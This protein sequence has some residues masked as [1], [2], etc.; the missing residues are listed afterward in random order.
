MSFDYLNELSWMKINDFLLSNESIMEPREFCVHVV[1]KIYSL[2]PYD[3]ARIYF[4]DYNGKVSDHVL[5]GVD[6]RWNDV[7]LEYY[8]R[9]ENGHYS[10]FKLENNSYL[11]P[12]INGKVHDWEKE[13]CDEFVSDYIKPQGLYH[14]LGFWLHNGE[15]LVT[16]VYS[17]DRTKH[18]EFT[19][20]EITAVRVVLPHL[21]NLYRN[22][23][24]LASSKMNHNNMEIPTPLTKREKEITELLRKGMT[25]SNISKKLFLSLPTIYK[26]IA[27]I[28][29]K[30]N[31]SNR[32]ELLLKL[33]N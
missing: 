21:N 13:P 33:M 18:K 24:A 6:K 10:I 26:H 4:L 8:S 23:L 12:E 28:H 11:I 32:Q 16:V 30:L 14:S 22:L 27:N 29:E 17:L 20:E 7:Y 5:I 31:V 19:Q 9:I 2:I 25:P 1:R 3:Q 15:K